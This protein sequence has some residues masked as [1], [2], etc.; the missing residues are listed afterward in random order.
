MKNF[1]PIILLFIC[2]NL[3]AQQK[4]DYTRSSLHLHLVDDFDYENGD[5]VLDSYEKFEFSDNYN[6]HTID[7]RKVKLSEFE[8]TDAEKDVAG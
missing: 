6:D 2:F 5:Y 4:N 3:A 1:S 7:F 8:L